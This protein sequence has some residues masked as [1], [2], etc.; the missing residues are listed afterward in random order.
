MHFFALKKQALGN[1]LAIILVNGEIM[2]ALQVK[3]ETIQS[4]RVSTI[5]CAAQ[6]CTNC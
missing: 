1:F 2:K 6:D 5:F 3:Y 4:C